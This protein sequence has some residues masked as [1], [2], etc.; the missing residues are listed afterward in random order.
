MLFEA[1]K[2]DSIRIRNA[3]A[4]EFTTAFYDFLELQYLIE[5]ADREIEQLERS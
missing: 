1:Q 5:A 2:L 3:V 4:L